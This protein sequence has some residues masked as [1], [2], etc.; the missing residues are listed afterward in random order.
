MKPSKEFPFTHDSGITVRR[1]VT[2]LRNRESRFSDITV[3]PTFIQE[4][5]QLIHFKHCHE[6]CAMGSVTSTGLNG[7]LAGR[8]GAGRCLLSFCL[9]VLHQRSQWKKGLFPYGRRSSAAR[10]IDSYFF[11]TI[12]RF[13]NA[14]LHMPSSKNARFI[15]KFPYQNPSRF[16]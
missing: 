16:V 14:P 13:Y 5:S 11:R 2:R 12:F 1:S 9:T 7:V 6:C 3:P 10:E 8:R 15:A 4:V